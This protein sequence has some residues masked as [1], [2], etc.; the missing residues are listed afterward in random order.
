M[1]PT[2]RILTFGYDAYVADWR[3]VVSQNLIANH[4]GNLLA[5]LSLYRDNDGTVGRPS[6][7]TSQ[8]IDTRRMNDRSYLSAI[9]WVDW[10]AR[11]YG[12][13]LVLGTALILVIGLIHVEATTGATSPLY[14]SVYPW[15]YFSRHAAPW[16]WPC[17]MG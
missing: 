7:S 5:S 8:G 1:V 14:F 17:Q 3:G 15:Y 9:A 4:A 6:Q 11:M 16:S 2:A 12:T 10:Y 13:A